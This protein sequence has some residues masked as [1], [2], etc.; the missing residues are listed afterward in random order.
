MNQLAPTDSH[1]SLDLDFPLRDPASMIAQPYHLYVEKID[2]S[3]NM[4]RYYAMSIEPTLFGDA[5]LTR[6][7]GLIG[8]GGQKLVHHFQCEE[9]AV[10]LFLALLRQKRLRGYGSKYNSGQR[11]VG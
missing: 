1:L 3:K 2:A 5:C 8:T 9:E 6:R 11:M 7:W 4:A 10:E